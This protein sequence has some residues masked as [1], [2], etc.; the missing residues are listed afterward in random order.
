MSDADTIAAIATPVGP[1]ARIIIRTSGPAAFALA[2]S[3]GVTDLAPA[4]VTRARLHFARFSGP[5]AVPATV[6]A[7]AAPRSA[8]GED[9]VEYHLPGVSLLARRL[10]DA[11]VASGARPARPGEFTA[12]AYFAGKLDLAAA[13]GVAAQIA[14]T[15]AAELDAARRLASGE[16]SRRLR[17][18]LDALADALALVEI[19]LDFAE[20]DVTAIA[21][22]DLLARLDALTSDLRR[23]L[24]ETSRFARLSHEPRVVL[25]GRPNA[26]KSTLLNALAGTSRAVVS[27]L[28]GTT[29]DAL[30]ARVA[31]RRGTVT[32]VDVAGVE[33]DYAGASVPTDRDDAAP[34]THAGAKRSAA[35]GGVRSQNATRGGAALGPGVKDVAATLASPD[36]VPSRA[37]QRAAPKLHSQMRDAADHA[38]AEA[39]VV[40]LAR[41]HTDAR[42]DPPLA[43][44]PDLRVLTKADLTPP[45]LADWGDAPAV[46]AATGDGL[47]ALRDRLDALAFGRDAGD[48]G[49]LALNARH[50]REVAAALDALARALASVGAGDEVVALELRAALDALGRVLGGVTPDDLLGR[51][52][53]S[54][55][56]GK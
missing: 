16:L 49:A 50:E 17:P 23:L 48:G 5:S 22:A 38:A 12:R 4:T 36:G 2:A 56:I 40:V 30:T 39:D 45:A 55:C 35:P 25:I 33:E 47:P 3:L 51:I 11:L 10:L 6:W 54:F 24:G 18:A 21:P 46:S 37:P 32:L 43:R 26:G 9:T 31:L 1:A 28:A 7:F 41:D 42:P 14:A 8:T 27:D 13:E 20:E 19:G 44:P 53:S 15:G 29:R 52:F 34:A